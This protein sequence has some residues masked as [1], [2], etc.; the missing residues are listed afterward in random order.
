MDRGESAASVYTAQTSGVYLQLQQ[1]QVVSVQPKPVVT[2]P[3]A[4]A[5]VRVMTLDGTNTVVVDRTNPGVINVNPGTRDWSSGL[6]GC[7][8]DIG[9]CKYRL[10]T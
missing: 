5:N 9:G 10:Y 4:Q 2:V 6:F 8:N 1:P 3:P 7:F